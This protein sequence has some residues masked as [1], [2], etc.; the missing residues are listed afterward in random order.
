M[1]KL[2]S[3]LLLYYSI[4]TFFF[5]WVVFTVFPFITFFV[6]YFFTE[7]GFGAFW[8]VFI[9]FSL[10]FCNISK[11]YFQKI[12]FQ[13]YCIYKKNMLLYLSQYKYRGV[14]QLV[15]RVVWDHEVARSIRVTPTK[16]KMFLKDLKLLGFRS[17][18]LSK[19]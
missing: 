3:I 11:K 6:Y 16:R 4:F 7:I 14:A 5:Q 12:L 19:F 17:F 8:F 13:K 9:S 10:H 18:I 1:F 2:I 15:E